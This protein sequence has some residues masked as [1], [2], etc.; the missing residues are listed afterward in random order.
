MT[1]H[2]CA[3]QAPSQAEVIGVNHCTESGSAEGTFGSGSSPPD[4]TCEMHGA[5]NQ[6][7]AEG[8]D[9]PDSFQDAVEEPR[10]DDDEDQNDEEA[11]VTQ[12]CMGETS[13]TWSLAR[14]AW[15]IVRVA[16][17]ERA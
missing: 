16:G 11:M 13:Y 14:P 7:Q 9:A 12:V 2:L 8:N 3:V 6:V 1:G 10:A 17:A 15:Q 4:G 5:D